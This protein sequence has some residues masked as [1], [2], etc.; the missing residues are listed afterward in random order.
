MSYNDPTHWRARAEDMRVLAERMKGAISRHMMHRIADD[1]ERLAQ[2]VEQRVDPFP[3]NPALLPAKL[4]P[5]ARRRHAGSAPLAGFSDAEIPG[6]LR[7]GP[8]MADNVRAP[9]V[10]VTHQA[11]DHDNKRGARGSDG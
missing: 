5:F 6:F 11:T 2:T 7:Q 10:S 4:R 3:P 9:A 1:Y 8:T